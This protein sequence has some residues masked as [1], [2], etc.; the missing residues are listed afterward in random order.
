[1]RPL[2]RALTSLG[3]IAVTSGGRDLILARGVPIG[4]VGVGHERKTGR[5]TLEA[6]ISVSRS[7]AIDAELDLAHGAIAPRFNGATPTTL[8]QVLGRSVELPAVVEAIVREL[9]MVAGGSVDKLALPALP[10]TR[11]NP[12][13]APF[14]AMVEEAIGLLGAVVEGD[15]V[16]IG[17]DLM[18]S[19]DVLADL[20]RRALRCTPEEL[21]AAIDEAFA[22]DAL[23]LGVRSHESLRKVISGATNANAPGS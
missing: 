4:W 20:G 12:D 10:A 22:G 15:A 17:G 19:S 18:A 9:A 16:T 14:T 13:E 2:L 3:D 23:L 21:G 6:V 8:E 11:A 7:F 5:T 1:V